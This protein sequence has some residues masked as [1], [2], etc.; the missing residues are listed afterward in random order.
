MIVGE[1]GRRRAANAALDLSQ[2]AAR[3]SRREAGLARRDQL[4]DRLDR[5]SNRADEL[6]RQLN[7]A[8]HDDDRGIERLLAAA[9]VPDPSEPN[10]IVTA[11]ID[12]WEALVIERK[13]SGSG[14]T[15]ERAE[16]NLEA[17]RARIAERRLA[18]ADGKGDGVRSATG[19]T[20]VQDRHAV[21]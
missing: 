4:V 13:A 10:P 15:A 19:V 6:E 1:L 18:V 2:R 9:R 17:I 12:E 8:D 16:A 5:L 21:V 7:T 14:P 20:R 11:L 3:V